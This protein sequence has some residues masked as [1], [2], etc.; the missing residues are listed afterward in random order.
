MAN[1]YL[2]AI[3]KKED[4]DEKDN[5]NPYRPAIDNVEKNFKSSGNRYKDRILFERAVDDEIKKTPP[6]F[7]KEQMIEL[8]ASQARF[9]GGTISQR[10][11]NQKTISLEEYEKNQPKGF[12]KQ[13]WED[14]TIVPREGSKLAKKGLQKTG[15]MEKDKDPNSIAAIIEKN[16]DDKQ[17]YWRQQR[18]EERIKKA[19]DGYE[20][21]LPDN[22]QEP[23]TFGI[24]RK[25]SNLVWRQ[26]ASALGGA[27][28][29]IG[30]QANSKELIDF[31]EGWS[32]KFQ[33]DILRHPEWYKPEADAIKDFA[34]GG[35][36]DTRWYARSMA[37]IIPSV[38]GVLTATVATTLATKNP[39]AGYA[40]GA[41]TAYSLESGSAYLEMLERGVSP[42]KAKGAAQIYGAAAASLEMISFIRVGNKVIKGKE[43]V[44]FKQ[45]YKTQLLKDFSK[46]VGIEA[47][48]EA[49]QQF[50]Q[51]VAT[52]FVDSSKPLFEGVIEA[53]AVGALG[54][55][56][57]GA[58]EVGFET[59]N[60]GR[61]DG[62]QTNPAPVTGE[63]PE[64]KVDSDYK[65][66]SSLAM[67]KELEKRMGG[68]PVSESS[69]TQQNAPGTT[70]LPGDT[71][72][73]VSG[74]SP[75]ANV[76]LN[77]AP[78]FNI[79]ANPAQQLPEI[80]VPQAQLSK[81]LARL[82]AIFNIN[83][84]NEQILR[85]LTAVKQEL[86]NFA[87]TFKETVVRIGKMF[88][89]AVVQFP[90]GKYGVSVDA[91]VG[92]ESLT[93]PFDPSET[94]ATRAE[95]IKAAVEQIRSFTTQLMGRSQTN[96]Q[97]DLF[98]QQL[99]LKL[100]DI[101]QAGVKEIGDFTALDDFLATLPNA[102]EVYTRGTPSDLQ[103]RQD[104]ISEYLSENF[105]KPIR[106]Q[107]AILGKENK[108]RADTLKKTLDRAELVVE[109][110][111]SAFQQK[112]AD[113]AIFD[114]KKL[115]MELID[116]Q[117]D[118]FRDTFLSTVYE[119][120]GLEVY[121][122]TPLK[123]IV[124]DQVE[125]WG[126]DES[127][128]EIDEA[129]QRVFSR[130]P[131]QKEN[132]TRIYVTAD[133]LQANQYV[134]LDLDT[135][136]TRGTFTEPKV[137]AD[138][139]NA[140]LDEYLQEPEAEGKARQ[141]ER[142]LKKELPAEFIV[143]D[144]RTDQDIQNEI[145]E[146]NKKRVAQK[147][148]KQTKQ[149]ADQFVLPG[150]VGKSPEMEAM[151]NEMMS[152]LQQSIEA[153]NQGDNAKSQ[154]LQKQYNA[155]VP[156]YNKL[157]KQQKANVEKAKKLELEEEAEPVKLGKEFFARVQPEKTG[158]QFNKVQGKKVDINSQLDTFIYKDQW[159]TWQVVEAQTGLAVG[160]GRTQKVAIEQAKEKIS[161]VGIEQ[162]LALVSDRAL[163]G[164]VSPTYANKGGSKGASVGSYNNE[165]PILLGNLQNIKPIAFPELV[166]LA[167]EL[168]AVPR[169]NRR[170]RN[171]RGRFTKFGIELNPEIFKD[172]VG[173]AKT[174]AHEIGHLID[175]L[176]DADL[177]RGNILGRLFT[178]KKFLKST[179]NK[180]QQAG[181]DLKEIR[182]QATKEVLAE[183]DIP[184]GDLVS[185]KLSGK[186]KEKI[187]NLIKQR[188]EKIIADIPG[189]VK[190][191][192]IY[193]ELWALSQYWR[194]VGEN[195]SSSFLAY[196]K[197]SDE[198]YADALSV[199]LNSPGLLE[200]KAPKFYQEFFEALDAK[201]EVR[202]AYF[203]LQNLLHNV[204]VLNE[205]RL[206]RI[207]E[208]YQRARTKRKEV[209]DR[210]ENIKERGWL[211]AFMQNHVTKFAPVYKRLK[212]A[213]KELGITNDKRTELR[214]AME[215][216]QMTRNDIYLFLDE[217]QQDIIA[218]LKE[219][220]ITEDEFGAVLELERNLNQRID[221]AN[222][223]GFLSESSKEVLDFIY[224]KFKPEQAHVFKQ[225]VERFHSIVF[226]YAEQAHQAGIYGEEVF[227]ERIEPFRNSYATFAVVDYIDSNYIGGSIKQ[228]KGTLKD[229]ENPLTSTV[230]KT[231]GVI[232]MLSTQKAKTE[233]VKTWKEMFPQELQLSDEVKAGDGTRRFFKQRDD[234]GRIE[235]YEDGKLVG[236]DFQD[237][238]I[239]T[240]FERHTPGDIHLLVRIAR[241][242]N[243]V[244]KPLV[245][246]YN[247]SWGFW[248][249]IIRDNKRT[250]KNLRAVLAKI[251]KTN[252]I[253]AI[254][255]WFKFAGIYGKTWFGSIPEA[256]KYNK[257]DLDA[258][259]REMLEN[260]AFS[261]PFIEY[262]EYAND[263]LNLSPLFKQ[264]N[265]L[266]EVE[267]S[268]VASG[269]GW[270]KLLTPF[271]KLLDGIK[272]AGSTLESTTKIAGYQL[273]K[274]R[275][276]SA[277]EAG[278]LTRNYVGTPNFFDGGL[279]KQTDNN[280]FVFSNVIIQGIR[281]ESELM[282]NPN[283][284]GGYFLN[285]L[286]LDIAPK[287]A[288]L[289]V[290]AG[291]FG[292][293]LK[294]LMDKATEYDKTN[295]L[296][297]PLGETAEGK[298]VYLRLP[299]DEMGRFFSALTWKAGNAIN[300]TLTK[301][302]QVVDIGAGFIP[303]A[304][305]IF[306]LAGAWL[307]YAR[308]VNPYDGFR[309]RPVLD[310]T[311]FQAG[312]VPAFSKMVMW[313][314]N[315]SGLTHFTT[316]DPDRQTKTEYTISLVPVVNRAIRITDYGEAERFGE[317]SKD[318]QKDR[319]RRTLE[320]RDVIKEYVQKAKTVQ[321]NAAMARLENELVKEVIGHNPRTSD[322]KSRATSL[323]TRFRASRKE[324]IYDVY[325][326]NLIRAN[327]N[328]EKL[329]L[330]KAYDRK[331]D[332]QK[333]IDLLDLVRKEKVIS[334]T[335]YRDYKRGQ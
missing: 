18:K 23:G 53:G 114:A 154:E 248:S 117:V 202:D 203:E 209:S 271:R 313:T 166:E 169:L 136:V 103:D 242:F 165:A 64:I 286:I 12:W 3:G 236:Y 237:K 119:A 280:V 83:P 67:Q 213:E 230:L 24:F 48:T 148:R 183:N 244:F 240:I 92:G 219:I 17:W 66:P 45:A 255:D 270:A 188:V 141:G 293:D 100:D 215:E 262:N 227:K 267:E 216:L 226:G 283:T 122:E 167:K 330:L 235:L 299:Q 118:D 133:K 249:N 217:I 276:A 78:Q 232:D 97:I 129:N 74:T 333:F 247:L 138:I 57:F 135:Q 30:R 151:D 301:P 195:P 158:I 164:E 308:G 34:K 56:G 252:G 314:M 239:A 128:P 156:K 175:Y 304:S 32:D 5:N 322:E 80:T 125:N 157:L 139:P 231:I 254:A 41:A 334:E 287:L 126:K 101:S 220:G 285:T 42:D 79:E 146:I 176:P 311:T 194:P 184:F 6:Q 258:L 331:L 256:Y 168:Q 89:M 208:G 104:Q 47:S 328:Q 224:K 274:K 204:D 161:G 84:E 31:G 2:Q 332:D 116:N 20:P 290:A 29:V 127:V 324:A 205:N 319:A 310:Q 105:E 282:G 110:E 26:I 8:A 264:Y 307:D 81:E 261:T 142:I 44:A 174:L 132:T 77:V 218:P 268:K 36:F 269:Q 273:L 10:D 207:Y 82:E 15:L 90:D 120:P 199:L 277:K 49:T 187:Q 196:R 197:G 303:T 60:K 130:A 214:M 306:S 121:F 326:D 75:V 257:G 52:K 243:R 22:Y 27:V 1:K 325:V 37:T 225:L 140:L 288:M 55:V 25:Y 155:L 250:F 223:G 189:T 149:V 291:L 145:T 72:T 38:T 284:R 289:G 178:L 221:V 206:N 302:Q 278:F 312:G 201:P 320:D 61:S 54:G 46:T 11:P 210:E 50:L 144:S 171:T 297:V 222:P 43:L 182:N 272:F 108:K 211:D 87:E 316:Y 191:K 192:E 294:E 111:L 95:A 295:Y 99:N 251:D 109:E 327:S 102:E 85:E 91:T 177:N 33:A 318:V 263:E 124:A 292:D 65:E 233:L 28:E 234:W 281:E 123:E 94:F 152:L 300:G 185:G 200:L 88:E 241:G 70:Q 73:P 193:E 137:V 86:M 321:G 228:V 7:T 266:G 309:G 186:K 14:L 162:T 190:K 150:G 279:Y 259:T 172:E 160:S 106:E 115:G 96:P 62:I 76:N 19:L 229:V 305:P 16:E 317:V 69:Q 51:N 329:E 323:K 253:T 39:V 113:L 21:K 147:T 296:V 107:I 98:V 134:D 13:M 212:Q 298:A 143:Y 93:V 238:Y 275:V 179:F 58:V 245:T 265:Y 68:S 35:A 159:G 173:A 181:L 71:N 198:V 180:E 4:E 246:T 131:V 163:K 315:Q 40:A 170:L 9:P 335:V 153:N 63:S 260:K 112:L 59:I